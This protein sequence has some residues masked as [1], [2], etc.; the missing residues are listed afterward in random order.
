MYGGGGRNYLPLKVNTSGV[1][2]V[3]FASSLLIVPQILALIPGLQWIQTSLV[4]GTFLYSVLY[5][6]MIIFFAYFWTYMFY[7]PQEIANNL[8]EYGSFLPG[9]RPGEHTAAYIHGILSRI[10]LVGA[11]FLCTIA[12]LP[13]LVA[14]SM[15]LTRAL[16]GFLG[17]TGILIIVGVCLDLVNK[18]ESYLLL[19]HYKGFTGSGRTRGRR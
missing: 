13:D 3:I 6:G 2:P 15:D 18:I 17:G 7:Q 16:T 9:I 14:Y 11:L 4:P 1:M 10:T 8:K 12:L 5:I 19:H